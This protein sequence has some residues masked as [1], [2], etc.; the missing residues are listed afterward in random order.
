M[1][2]NAGMPSIGVTWGVHDHSQLDAEQPIAIMQA[3]EELP[4]LLRQAKITTAQS[5]M[6]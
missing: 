6:A 5:N 1:A 3:I 4:H 2:K